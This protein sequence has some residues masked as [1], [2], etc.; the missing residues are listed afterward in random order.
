MSK[1]T[2]ASAGPTK[3]QDKANQA[4]ITFDRKIAGKLL[5]AMASADTDGKSAKDSRDN[6]SLD[7]CRF[8]ASVVVANDGINRETVTEGFC[9]HLDNMR[10]ML[11]TEDNP[12]VEIITAEGK[13]PRYVWKG[14]GNNVKSIARGVTEFL[15][16]IHKDEEGQEYPALCNLDEAKSFTEVKKSVEAARRYG[17]KDDA[18]LLREAKDAL[19]V[20]CAALITEVIKSDDFELIQEQ[21]L[22]VDQNLEDW[23]TALAEQNKADE[24]AKAITI[25]EPKAVAASK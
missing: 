2:K 6:A 4:A 3:S 22:L 19:R 7:F 9:A 25:D 23:V 13:D 1:T 11:A 17:E 8:A 16:I 12:F 18:R 10:P 21:A 15:A 24:A 5:R 14:H 20:S